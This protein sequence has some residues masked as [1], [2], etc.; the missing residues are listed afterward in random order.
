MSSEATAPA[1]R[2]ARDSSIEVALVSMPFGLLEEPSVALGLLK[3]SLNGPR[4]KALYF[5]LR[6]AHLIG[7]DFYDWV[8]SGSRPLGQFLGEYLFRAA[9]FPG[10]D[11]RDEDFWT[12]WIERK[13]T[14]G[15]P[16]PD[17]LDQRLAAAGV[18][19]EA[20]LDECT[21]DILT[22]QPKIVGLTSVF[23][24]QLASLALARRLKERD[25][26]L[27]IVCGGANCEGV[28]GREMMRQFDVLD[29]VVSG[30]G[31][32]V[33]PQLVDRV[34]SGD[35]VDGLRGVLTAGE[36]NLPDGPVIE[37]PKVSEMDALPT[38][39]YGDYFEA[40]AAYQLVDRLQPALPFETSR[41][42]WWG[43]KQHCTFCG[44]NGAG[45]TFRSKSSNRAL[46]ELDALLATYPV[47]R[48]QFVD[49]ILDMGY[50][51]TFIPAL[52]E[53]DW[54]TDS[55]FEVKAN[56]SKGHLRLLKAAGVHR[57]QPGIESLSRRVLE[58]MGKGVSVLQ[59]I[60]LLKWCQ[61]LGIHPYW[62][63]LWGF[64]EEEPEDYAEMARLIPLLSHLTPPG[65]AGPLRLDRFSP[66]FEDSASHGFV[67]VEPD[68]AYRHLY[69]VEDGALANLAYYFEYRYRDDRDVASY[70]ATT[71]EAVERWR[72][73]HVSGG[74]LCLESEEGLLI[75]D[76]R[77]VA[78]A[79]VIRLEGMERRL[80]GAC[81]D[82]RHLRQLSRRLG[83]EAT[84]TDVESRLHGL[85][86]QGLMMREGETF[87]SL[88]VRQG[89]DETFHH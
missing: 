2:T 36:G 14:A 77:P 50:F 7:P 53:Q 27:F 58:A 15:Q 62:N 24:Q 19:V 20:F 8:S 66:N 38:P 78:T 69:P 55:F 11:W 6:F 89:A 5:N 86:E 71:H 87:L 82:I 73:E 28:M 33:F 25:P 54:K 61:E 22:L 47:S 74:L 12:R 84:P 17:R 63:I 16:A 80:Y 23:Q 70:T 43:A 39:D 49:N 34:L 1:A 76:Q 52:A 10:V 9:A 59:N 65:V 37:A 88:A 4:C 32:I 18:Q 30:E 60:R 45:M 79:P 56:L 3:A 68:A 21:A 67:D 26:D 81:D 29:A 44:L 40:L 48:V 83:G 41:G 31:D 46:A 42:C 57:I 72:R 35:A 51:K 13:A 64:P 75:W 85:V